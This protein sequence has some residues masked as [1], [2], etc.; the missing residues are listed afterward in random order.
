MRELWKCVKWV[1]KVIKKRE[2]EWK[3]KGHVFNPWS[4]FMLWSWEIVDAFIHWIVF[5][6][7]YDSTHLLSCPL[8]RILCIIFVLQSNIVIII[9]EAKR[10]KNFHTF[11]SV[12]VLLVVLSLF[13]SCLEWYSYNF[14]VVQLCTSL[15]QTTFSC[16][17]K[18]LYYHSLNDHK[19]PVGIYRVNWYPL[20]LF[21]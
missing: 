15:Y 18:F 17:T 16:S 8:L 19:W 9:T 11:Q 14:S 6:S 7:V 10:S 4:D 3:M 2:R 12:K 20:Y 13:Q 5:D 21:V 1:K